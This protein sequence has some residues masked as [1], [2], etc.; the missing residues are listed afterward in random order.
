MESISLT[1]L[2]AEKLARPPSGRAAHHPTVVT[3]FGNWH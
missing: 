2:A 1:N 3:G